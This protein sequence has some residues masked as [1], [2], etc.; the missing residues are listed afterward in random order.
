MRSLTY[1][2]IYQS[3]FDDEELAFRARYPPSARSSQVAPSARMMAPRSPNSNIPQGAAT[4]SQF[5]SNIVQHNI[6]NIS[7]RRGPNF[8]LGRILYLTSRWRPYIRTHWI[9]PQSLLARRQSIRYSPYRIPLHARYTKPRPFSVFIGIYS[10]RPTW[11]NELPTTTV[12]G[13]SS[14]TVMELAR[15]LQWRLRNLRFS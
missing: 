10:V 6:C 9:A 13:F 11:G 4:I 7:F 8:I 5:Y 12:L 2:Y 1:L 15:S 3:S 14:F